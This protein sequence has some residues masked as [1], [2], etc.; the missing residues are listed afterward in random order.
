VLDAVG[1]SSFSRCARL[2]A[3]RGQYLSTVPTLGLMASV[4]WTAIRPGKRARFVAA[5]LQ[6]SRA[7][8]EL[9]RGLF[10]AKALRSVI[11]RRFALAQTAEAFRYVE[12][13]RKKGS[14]I[15]EVSAPTL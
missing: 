8:L 9:L 1:T 6:Q 7:N 15:L 12:T 3:P 4:L 5:G 10:D 2:L 11:D 14:V 13:G